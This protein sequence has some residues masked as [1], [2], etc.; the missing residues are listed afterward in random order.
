MSPWVRRVFLHLLPSLLMV[1]RPTFRRRQATADVVTAV[2]QYASTSLA[3]LATSVDAYD[4]EMAAAFPAKMRRAAVQ[5]R[6]EPTTTLGEHLPEC[7][8]LQ[9]KSPHHQHH[10]RTAH[11]YHDS[12]SDEGCVVEEDDE[13]PSDFGASSS[14]NRQSRV[15]PSNVTTH[16]HHCAEFIRALESVHWIA[17]QMR[18]DNIGEDVSIS[19]YLLYG[20]RV[21][22]FG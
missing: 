10:H 2:S 20:N 4:R 3:D 17:D 15:S 12:T 21:I 22:N 18:D 9:Q 14:Y 8:C 1:K 13:I 6:N 11:F 19:V 5:R 7:D 16:V